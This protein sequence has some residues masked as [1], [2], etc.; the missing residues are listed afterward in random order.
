QPR[1]EA[2]VLRLHKAHGSIVTAWLQ[3]SLPVKEAMLCDLV[4]RPAAWG[5]LALEPWG[6]RLSL[7]PFRVLSILLVHSH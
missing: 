6:L 2:V 1:P 3:S 7:M 5:H 4:E